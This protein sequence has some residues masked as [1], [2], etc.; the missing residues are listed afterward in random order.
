MKPLV[1]F[2]LISLLAV[3][4]FAYDQKVTV[5]G[6]FLC[7]NVISNGTEMILKEH[8]WI[9]FDDVLSTAATY[10]N[11]SFEITGYENEFFK[12]SPYLE[13]IH[14]CGVTQGSVAMCSITTLWI[15]EG[16]SYYKMGTI[17]LLDQ[18]ASRPK[19]CSIQRAFF[20]KAKAVST[21]WNI[22]GL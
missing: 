15:P 12:I 4:T 7:G 14:S 17:N 21:V 1:S 5:V 8:D 13:V 18:Q 3:F 9:D 16:I 19:G 2:L 10:E 6:N 22:F 20:L 11:G